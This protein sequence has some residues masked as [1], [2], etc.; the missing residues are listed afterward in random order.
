MKKIVEEYIL[1]KISY[2]NTIEIVNIHVDGSL[3][4][5]EYYAN[6]NTYYKES[7]RINMWDMLVFVNDKIK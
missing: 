7:E 3:C 5:V 1:S 2:L 6:N 4:I